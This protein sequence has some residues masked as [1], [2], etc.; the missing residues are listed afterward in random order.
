MLLE[1]GATG[2]RTL[3]VM[4]ERGCRGQD[5]CAFLSRWMEYAHEDNHTRSSCVWNPWEQLQCCT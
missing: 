4:L 5:A 3:T 1:E 2:V